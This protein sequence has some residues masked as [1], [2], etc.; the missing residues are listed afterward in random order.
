MA[1]KE[2][3]ATNGD[4]QAAGDEAA[5]AR[6]MRNKLLA[7]AFGEIVSVLMRSPHYKHYSLTDL[8][9]LVVPPL[10]N[11]Q[12]S[13]AEAHNKEGGFAAPVGVALWASVSEEV[14][15]KLAEGLDR[16]VRL[17]PDEWRSGDILWM[18]DAVGA[19]Q[20]VNALL[21]RLGSTVF[22]NKP[23]KIRAAD[24]EGK[25]SVKVVQASEKPKSE[26]ED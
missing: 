1:E 8:E 18:V 21:E 17:R 22:Q 15:Q 14:D 7:A 9:W 20:T 12:F 13:L 6:A 23:F 26:G 5:R 2:T 24:N 19:P 25:R 4:G 10:L 11:N 3:G 16:P